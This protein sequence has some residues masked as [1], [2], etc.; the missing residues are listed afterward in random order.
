MT[1]ERRDPQPSSGNTR[2]APPSIL[3]NYFSQEGAKGALVA[4]VSTIGFFLLALVV[5][6]RSENWPAVQRSFFNW[7]II[8]ESFPK[9]WEGFRTNVWMFLIGQVAIMV[10]AL[11]IAMM[12]SLK[13]PAFFPLRLLAVIYIDF[14]RGIPIILGLYLF[15]FGV[16][17]LRLPGLPNSAAFWGLLVVV[18]SYSAYTAE[19]YRS[20]IDAVPDSQ[21]LS[22]ASLG[23]T[24]LQALRYA[25]LPQAIRNVIPALLNGFVSL[26]KDV[27]LLAVLGVREAVREAQIAS[28]RDFNYSP[29]IAATFLFLAIS[30]P[31]ARFADW[32]TARDRARRSQ[33]VG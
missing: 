3:G 18:L 8:T 16:P 14:F 15:G 25:V 6:G 11:V 21:R 9:V 32:Y 27:A 26:Q 22:A 19:V 23:L 29:Y 17:A 5:I 1:A 20:G 7:D 2:H 24:Q 12:R 28:G 33:G 4:F 13:G 31:S 30:V 10:L